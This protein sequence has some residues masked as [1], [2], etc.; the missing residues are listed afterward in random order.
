MRRTMILN[1]VATPA[2]IRLVG[3]QAMLDRIDS[4][5]LA[6]IAVNGLDVTTTQ[7]G[8]LIV[9]EGLRL[10]DSTSV[11]VFAGGGEMI[12]SQTFEQVEILIHGNNGRSNITLD[13][14]TVT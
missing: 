13:I 9:P 10:L 5:Q 8:E 1:A 3:E 11:S 6:P 14:P 2:T 12:S 7:T 4:I